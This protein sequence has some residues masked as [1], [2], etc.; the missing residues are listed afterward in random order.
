M[1]K[2]GIHHQNVLLTVNIS[3]IQ[4]NNSLTLAF[5]RNLYKFLTYFN[6]LTE[7]HV[8]QHDTTYKSKRKKLRL[9]INSWNWEGLGNS[10]VMDI[11]NE[12]HFQNSEHAPDYSLINLIDLFYVIALNTFH[13]ETKLIFWNFDILEG[14]RNYCLNS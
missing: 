13:I 1:L 12:F 2:E 8:I 5:Q 10:S 11:S 14:G 4:F 3:F 7:I 6:I 9:A